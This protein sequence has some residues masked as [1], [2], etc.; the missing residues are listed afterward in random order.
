MIQWAILDLAIVRYAD[1]PEG[2]WSLLDR[3]TG[4]VIPLAGKVIEYGVRLYETSPDLLLIT[5]AASSGNR[6]VV[7]GD[8]FHPLISEATLTALPEGQLEDKPAKFFNFLRITHADGITEVY[9]R[10][11][12]TVYG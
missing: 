8:T 4:A 12:L 9:A 6:I 2:V 11:H 7:V 10:G 3:E 1:W 5:S